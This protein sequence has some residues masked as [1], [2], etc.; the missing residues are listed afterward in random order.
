MDGLGQ[1]GEDLALVGFAADEGKGSLQP[2]AVW[3]DGS[4]TPDLPERLSLGSRCRLARPSLRQGRCNQSSALAVRQA[5]SLGEHCD[6][7]LA[8]APAAS[9][10]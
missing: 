10:L 1:G 9:V 8:R 7:V 4:V 5:Q 3:T 6:R 2:V